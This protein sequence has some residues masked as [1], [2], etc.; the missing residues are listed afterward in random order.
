MLS[1]MSL[2]IS[3][4]ERSRETP[5]SSGL[6]PVFTDSFMRSSPSLLATSQSGPHQEAHRDCREQGR[7]R[8]AA[9]NFFDVLHHAP[10]IVLADILGCGFKF[11]SRPVSNVR[12]GF[13]RTLRAAA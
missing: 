3:A 5:G 6:V 1:I 13:T 12:D 2:R 10:K 11:F 7:S 9:D 4:I 8:I